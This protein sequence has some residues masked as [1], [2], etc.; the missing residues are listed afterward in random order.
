MHRPGASA[1][2]A[3][4]SG[5]S[6]L[7]VR[8]SGMTLPSDH[9]V[10]LHSAAGGPEVLLPVRQ[11]LPA[12]GEGEILIRVA[13]AGV[14]RHDLGQRRRAPGGEHTDVFGLEVAGEVVA[15][16]PGVEAWRV[17]D[18]VC[19]LVDGGGYAEYAVAPASNTL[20]V[21][22][23]F[24]M[25]DAAAL[26]EALFTVWYNFFDVGRLQ[27]GERVLIHGGT[28]GVGSIGLQLLAALDYEA[29]ATCGDDRKCEA[30]RGFGARVAINYRT[31]DFVAAILE[32][33]AG[34]GVD[35]VLD[36]AGGAYAEKNLDAL[37]FGGRIVHLSPGTGNFCPP[38]AKIM[39]KRA[40][41]TGSRLRPVPVAV[42]ARM[43]TAIARTVWP[44]LG[45]SV[46]PVIDAT[47]P[48]A[49]AADAHRAMERAAHIGK[50]V[51]VP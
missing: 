41:V 21:P 23:G 15:L 13:A 4:A 25:P 37:A 36:M 38:L 1:T 5:L 29:Y 32:A 27:P 46:R 19:A 6:T 47:F 24:G 11:P 8:T 42:K 3:A 45:A 31:A 22:S 26:P 33:T 9:L 14:N 7:A 12:P 2:V 35:L 48:L 28:S 20:P 51:L 44:L 40:C 34:R 17:G 49:R 10:V 18:R 30:A 43:A 16:G 39:A 50:I